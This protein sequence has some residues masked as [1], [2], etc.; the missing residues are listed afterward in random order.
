MK[1][2]DQINGLNAEILNLSYQV[3]SLTTENAISKEQVG[4]LGDQ[5]HHF[6]HQLDNTDELNYSLE[7]EKVDFLSTTSTLILT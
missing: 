2:K 7:N 5:V 3:Y 6:A 1:L 4:T